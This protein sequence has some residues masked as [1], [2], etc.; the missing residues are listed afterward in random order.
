VGHKKKIKYT[1]KTPPFLSPVPLSGFS[2]PP[3]GGVREVRL[4][5][6]PR[7]G[8][9][10]H[11]FPTVWRGR[12]GN[13]VW[14]H[15]GGYRGLGFCF[16]PGG[17]AR[18]HRGGRGHLRWGTTKNNGGGAL[19]LLVG[20]GLIHERQGDQIHPGNQFSCN[21]FVFYWGVVGGGLRECGGGG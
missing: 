10:F 18:Y 4:G 21:F 14:K 1:Y 13:S 17:A 7:G 6:P 15:G 19:F 20:G 3:G 12:L 16:M 5:A 9:W 8:E 11:L 2:G